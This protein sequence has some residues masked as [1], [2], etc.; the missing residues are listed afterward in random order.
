MRSFYSYAETTPDRAA[1]V[2]PDGTTTSFGDLAARVNQLTHLIVARDLDPGASVCVLLPNGAALLAVQRAVL[3]QPL[4][5][6][7]INWHFA[8]PEVAHI[9]QDSDAR[10]VFTTAE[11]ARLVREACLLAGLPTDRIVELDRT[12]GNAE[13]EAHPLTRPESSAGGSRML[14]TSGTT[15]KPKGVRRPLPAGGPDAVAAAAVERAE[16]YDVNH[17]GGVYLSVAPMYHAAPLSYADQALEVGHTVVILP[18]WS[19]VT[20]LD[21]IEQYQVTWAYLVPLMMQDMLEVRDSHRVDV[22]SLRTVIHTAAP[23]PPSV[24]RAMIDWLGPVLNEVYGGT[25]GSATL[26]TSKE[27][28]ARPGSVGRAR[29]GVRITIR[30]ENGEG[31]PPGEIGAIYFENAKTPFEYHNAPE[32][33][34]SSRIAN[35]I[36][37]GDIGYLDDDG[38]LYL[39]DRTAD[40]IISG[41]VNVYPA[42]IEHA[43]VELPTIREAC[44][45]GRPDPRWGESVHAVVVTAEPVE[46]HDSLRAEVETALRTKIAGYKVPRT[47]EFV[48]ELPH[49]EVGKL[50]RRVV[51]ER[52]VAE[53][54]FANGGALASA[55]GVDGSN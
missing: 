10:I 29:A 52:V 11:Y 33:T 22:S 13:V 18:R 5:L 27:W 14:Y 45:V 47:F 51:R 26:I 54:G 20:A 32:K 43:L 24:K 36:T 49:S 3:Q 17:E 40:T 37:L 4:Y 34:K 16:K 6:T 7:T 9:L 12:G 35:E 1:V 31:L 30:G 2:D 44:V 25:E 38:Y 48:D 19:A 28:L 41:G 50:L 8:A 21:A 46:D 55:L 15:G 53:S 23:C 42:E 39:C